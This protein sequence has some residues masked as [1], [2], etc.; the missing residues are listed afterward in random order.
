MHISTSLISY[1][2][3]A[4]FA[5]APVFAADYS[6]SV[7][8]TEKGKSIAASEYADTVV[9]FV[10]AKPVEA[11]TLSTETKEIVMK[12][13]GFIPRVLPIQLGTTVSFPNFDPILHN[14]FSTSPKNKFDLGLYGGGEEKSHT[15]EKT[16]LVRVYCNVHHNMVAYILSFDS[17]YFTTPTSSGEFILKDLPSGSGELVLWHPRAKA[18]KQKIDLSTSME[19]ETFELKLTKRRIPK[20]KNKFGKSY[21]RSKKKDY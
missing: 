2:L 13:K 8:I 4:I 20:H 3:L 21:R 18:I 10:P 14:A 19:G 9:Y 12:K 5:I 11:V 7:L 17:P 6:G 16:G 15:F 1:F